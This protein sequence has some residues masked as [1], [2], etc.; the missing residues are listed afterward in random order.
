MKKTTCFILVVMLIFSSSIVYSSSATPTI[1]STTL[2]L[3]D[4]TYTGEVVNGKMHGE[5]IRKFTKNNLVY[6]GTFQDD[7]F[8]NGTMTYSDN[9]FDYVYT[10]DCNNSEFSGYGVWTVFY[11]DSGFLN[12]EIE[13][14]WEPENWSA[15]KEVTYSDGIRIVGFFEG[16]QTFVN[17]EKYDFYYPNGEICR[18]TIY[19]KKTNSF[20]KGYITEMAIDFFD[21]IM[22]K[23]YYTE[24]PNHR[25]GIDMCNY[26]IEINPQF[27]KAYYLKSMLLSDT[28]G[29]YDPDRTEEIECY[30]SMM[31]I[32]ASNSLAYYGMGKVLYELEEFDAALKYLDKAVEQYSEKNRMADEMFSWLTLK[33]IKT[34]IEEVKNGKAFGAYVAG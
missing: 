11:K 12:F 18:D 17:G 7:I 29:H 34:F 20:E 5:G 22:S 9:K 16:E 30:L 4:G 8:V 1:T 32:D 31:S 15:Y 27:Y 28:A 6:K 25:R 13:Q 19:N 24:F 10:G 3:K 21:R 33:R 14:Y 26:L 2:K 23:T